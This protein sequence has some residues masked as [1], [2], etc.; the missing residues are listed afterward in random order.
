MPN[1]ALGIF[2]VAAVLRRVLDPSGGLA[3][4]V[5]AVATGAL[6]WWAVDEVV[7]GVNPFR[8]LVGAAVLA[9]TIVG[10]AA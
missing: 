6:L 1:L 3:T 9:W 2:L 5:D 7:R 4:A 10:F 8:R